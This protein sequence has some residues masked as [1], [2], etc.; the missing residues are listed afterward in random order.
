MPKGEGK[1]D[2]K[3]QIDKVNEPDHLGLLDGDDGWSG[4]GKSAF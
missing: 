1:G 4:T 3:D 2:D